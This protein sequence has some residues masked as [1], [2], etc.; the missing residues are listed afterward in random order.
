VRAVRDFD[1]LQTTRVAGVTLDVDGR[2]GNLPQSM[3]K[4][5]LKSQVASTASE[6]STPF[7]SPFRHVVDVSL[8]SD[9]RLQNMSDWMEKSL[10]RRDHPIR[11]RQSP[12]KPRAPPCRSFATGADATSVAC[13]GQLKDIGQLGAVKAIS[14]REQERDAIENE[15]PGGPARTHPSI[16]QILCV[17]LHDHSMDIVTEYID[18]GMRTQMMGDLAISDGNLTAERSSAGESAAEPSEMQ[19]AQANILR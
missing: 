2:F 17:L 15:V 8:D 19:I 14:L 9:L 1:L 13:R 10:H 5:L 12:P 4:F 11:H 3:F 6:D 16:V 18:G 7:D